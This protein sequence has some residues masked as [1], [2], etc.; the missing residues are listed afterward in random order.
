MMVEGN[1]AEGKMARG[2]NGEE[3]KLAGEIIFELVISKE[4][5]CELL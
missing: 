3:E 4:N 2:D 1:M 5:T